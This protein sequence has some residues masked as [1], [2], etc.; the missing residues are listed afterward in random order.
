[1]NKEKSFIHLPPFGLGFVSLGIQIVFIR[2]LLEI[3]QGNELSV[4]LVLSVWLIGSA[5]GAAVFQPLLKKLDLSSALPVI[6]FPILLT[7]YFLIKITP[8]LFGLLPG[9]QL[10][11]ESMVWVSLGTIIP[12][13]LLM[14]ALFPC[15]VELQSASK[16]SKSKNITE[17]YQWE[18]MGAFAAGL[19]LNFILFSV[20]NSFQI[21]ILCLMVFYLFLPGNLIGQFTILKKV[22]RLR[23]IYLFFCI[24]L[25]LSGPVLVNY[26]HAHIYKP[27]LIL[28]EKDTPYGNLKVTRLEKQLVLFSQG[29]VLY[30][31]PDPFSAESRT[32]LPLLLH[33]APRHILILGGNLVGYLPYL[34]HIP[35]VTQIVY[36]EIDPTL[37]EFQRKLIDSTEF[38]TGLKLE[39]VVSDIRKF[40]TLG[41]EKYDLIC[42]NQPEASTLNLNRLYSQTFVRLVKQRLKTGGIYFFTIRS[43][44]NYLNADLAQYINIL[45]NTVESVF[46]SVFIV[47]GDENHFLASD[48][49]Y[50]TD[51]LSRYSEKLK[52]YHLRPTYFVPAYLNFRL[53]GERVRSFAEQLSRQPVTGLNTDFNLKAYL[54]HFRVWNRVY[55]LRTKHVF[56]FLNK[57]KFWLI[58]GSLLLLF[59]TKI[60]LWRRSTMRLLMRLSI[61]GGISV[62]LEIIFMLEY[63]VLFGTLY[64]RIAIIFSLYMIGL[65]SGTAIINKLNLKKVKD[66]YFRIVT[67]GLIFCAILFIPLIIFEWQ[68]I[69]NSVLYQTMQ[70][71]ILPLI[72]FLIGLFT[73][74]YFSLITAAFYAGNKI[75]AAGLTYGAD[76]AGAVIFS[77][78]SSL[79]LIPIFGVTGSLFF[80]IVLLIFVML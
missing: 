3:F 44:E 35:S 13:A 79:V 55:G 57:Y 69:S 38:R 77:F 61:I 48:T 33:P 8:H 58:I 65:A 29:K 19:L 24:I 34:E 20:L 71:I 10:N 54:Y 46:T 23:I 12:A 75:S 45:K 49:N 39:F 47:P 16:I 5:L 14:G 9:A 70:W 36:V 80:V 73:G 68:I 42:L 30:S 66:S 2:L 22:N 18:S 28:S 41:T 60:V 11:L 52:T 15:L 62:A 76:L 25:L 78:L 40:L 59:I 37:V 56:N 64:S 32:L 72:I 50:F 21:V 27:Y 7:D 26:F 74:N 4:G 6:L 63:Q 53:S 67:I 1:M 51:I 17:I 43:S 31:T